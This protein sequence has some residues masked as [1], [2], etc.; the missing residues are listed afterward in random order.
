MQKSC[1]YPAVAIV[2]MILVGGMIAVVMFTTG[3][4]FEF[5][6]TLVFTLIGAIAGAAIATM[7]LFGLRRRGKDRFDGLK[8]WPQN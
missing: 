8:T 2:F 3:V 1:R 6:R 5:G 4:A 7:L